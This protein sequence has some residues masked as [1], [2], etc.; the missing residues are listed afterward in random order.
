[1]SRNQ[2]NDQSPYLAGEVE[3]DLLKVALEK[4]ILAHAHIEQVYATVPGQYHKHIRLLSQKEK[5]YDRQFSL[6]PVHREK[7]LVS[8][9]GKTYVETFRPYVD[10]EGRI[11]EMIDVHKTHSAPYTLD[12][13]AEQIGDYWVMIC[14]FEGLNKNGQLFKTKE[15]AIIG[16]G[17]T[18]VDATNPI[19]NA[20]TS[21]VGRALSH[22]GYGNIGSGLSSFEDIY[23]AVSRQKA[24][25]KLKDDGKKSAG[26][27]EKQPT[28]E[29]GGTAAQGQGQSQ[30]SG[31]QTQGSGQTPPATNRSQNQSQQSNRSSGGNT[32][33]AGQ[34]QTRSEQDKELQ[35]AKNQLVGRL[36]ESS[37]NMDKAQL[38]AK[39][40]EWLNASREGS[41]KIIW[42]GK[43]NNLTVGQLR[44]VEEHLKLE[45]KR[46]EQAS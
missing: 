4:R 33:T 39:V 46:Q 35:R 19:E 7:G 26:T 23:I 28:V 10:V 32:S 15:R 45:K 38:K 18:G 3:V 42:D 36:M 41:D 6:G 8:Y 40:N 17:G 43:F 5:I 30:G 44:L 1:M 9:Y 2:P 22:G 31:Q 21:A 34:R 25:D 24:L 12:T 29:T 20:S 37:K 13:Y 27:G 11:S 16:F 14:S